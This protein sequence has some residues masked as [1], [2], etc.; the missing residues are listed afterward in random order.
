MPRTLSAL[1]VVLTTVA[2]V[3]T[4]ADPAALLL[5]PFPLVR[6]AGDTHYTSVSTTVINKTG[7]GT[8]DVVKGAPTVSDSGGW[9]KFLSVKQSSPTPPHTNQK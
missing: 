8:V 3:A 2:A 4:T 6:S 7:N 5:D 1:A 9:K